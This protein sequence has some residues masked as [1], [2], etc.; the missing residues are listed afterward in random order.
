MAHNIINKNQNKTINTLI[1]SALWSEKVQELENS[2]NITYGL[3]GKIFQILDTEENVPVMQIIPCL[4]MLSKENES[5]IVNI[6]KKPHKFIR[7]TKNY[8]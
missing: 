4:A 8:L 2:I 3:L 1:V 6:V 5:D 7:K